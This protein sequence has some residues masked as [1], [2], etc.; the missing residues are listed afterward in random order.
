MT[1]LYFYSLHFIS[2][3][4]LPSPADA[5]MGAVMFPGPWFLMLTKS[6]PLTKV[7]VLLSSFNW[8]ED[9]SLLLL[10]FYLSLLF[11]LP[12]RLKGMVLTSR[13]WGSFARSPQGSCFVEALKRRS[14]RMR[15]SP[16]FL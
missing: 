5:S 1:R 4:R 9:E 6:T 8:M 13:E 14:S 11:S 16:Y 3:E 12:V 15:C 10:S 2:N 7:T